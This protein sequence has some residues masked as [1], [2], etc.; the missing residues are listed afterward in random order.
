MNQKKHILNLKNL[1]C[2]E[3]IMM[4]RKKIREINSGEKILIFSDDPS[5]KRDIPKFCIFMNHKLLYTNFDNYN[6][7]FLIQK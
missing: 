1:R 7:Q 3:P 5:T 6:F 4:L 2:P